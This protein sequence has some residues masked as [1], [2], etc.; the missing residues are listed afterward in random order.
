MQRWRVDLAAMPECREGRELAVESAGGDR[1]VLRDVL[2][3][4]V[5]IVSGQSNCELPLVGENPHFSDS[6][7]PLGPFEAEIR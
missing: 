2:V 6:G 7:L 1:M 4:E 5:W 3:G